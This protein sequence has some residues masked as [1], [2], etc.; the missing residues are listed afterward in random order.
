MCLA[1]CL[2]YTMIFQHHHFFCFCRSAHPQDTQS[3][4][5]QKKPRWYNTFTSYHTQG[6]FSLDLFQS[7]DDFF[8]FLFLDNHMVAIHHDTFFLVF[9]G[10]LMMFIFLDSI[11]LQ[12][13]RTADSLST[14]PCF[15]Y[16]L[17]YVRL[18]RFVSHPQK[19]KYTT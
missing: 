16:S 10:N 8:K 18:T 3:H 9:V 13:K 1:H 15:H 4:F 19:Y 2:H 14:V 12:E 11:S 6:A 5:Q 7:V 17:F